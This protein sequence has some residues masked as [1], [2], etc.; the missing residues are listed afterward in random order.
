MFCIRLEKNVFWFTLFM[1]WY[2]TVRGSCCVFGPYIMCVTQLENTLSSNYRLLAPRDV[3]AWKDTQYERP[4]LRKQNVC[5]MVWEHRVCAT[6]GEHRVC[7]NY[8]ILAPRVVCSI[9]LLSLTASLTASIANKSS[10]SQFSNTLYRIS[11]LQIYWTSSNVAFG[12]GKALFTF[13]FRFR[14]LVPIAT[15]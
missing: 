12:G 7:A 3:F 13:Y 5:A 6:I 11:T 15:L 1:E 9:I 10:L 4:I 2:Y 8:R 14:T